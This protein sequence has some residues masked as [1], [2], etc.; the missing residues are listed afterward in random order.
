MASAFACGAHVPT[1]AQS[2]S[3]CGIAALIRGLRPKCR[4]TNIDCIRSDRRAAA[5]HTKGHAAIGAASHRQP[6]LPEMLV[7]AHMRLRRSGLIKRK[8]AVD[9]QPELARS[10]RLPKIGAHAAADLSHF[11]ERAGT[12]GH[13]DI[14]DPPQG[15]EVEVEFGLHAGEAA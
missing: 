2:A 1:R 11:V 12:K 8:A 13:A 3:R 14:V 4:T 10:H 6:N 5:V 15:M 7:L 9:R